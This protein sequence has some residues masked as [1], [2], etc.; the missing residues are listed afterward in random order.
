M[1]TIRIHSWFLS[2]DTDRSELASAYS[3]DATFS[4]SFNSMSTCGDG[5][6]DNST[7]PSPWSNIT[8]GLKQGCLEVL[9]ALLS[10]PDDLKLYPS[11]GG[12]LE[13]DLAVYEIHGVERGVLVV[14]YSELG[15]DSAKGKGKQKQTLA[16]GW[17]CDHHFV[18]KHRE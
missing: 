1:T 11:G 18:L 8:P 15:S 14:S 9:S 2:F 6:V 13:Y 16:D 12:K 4:I 17:G 10:L 7:T 3:E 5:P